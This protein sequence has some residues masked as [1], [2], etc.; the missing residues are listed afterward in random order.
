M[1]PRSGER[2]YLRQKVGEME[3]ALS[4]GVGPSQAF[5]HEFWSPTFWRT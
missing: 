3:S 5:E 4:F 2:S 1:P